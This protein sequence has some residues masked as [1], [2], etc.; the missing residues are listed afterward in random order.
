MNRR[1]A[2][3]SQHLFDVGLQ[4]FR[5]LKRRKKRFI[6]IFFRDLQE[7]GDAE[8]G[9]QKQILG[10]RNYSALAFAGFFYFIDDPFRE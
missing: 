2:D 5:I 1:S 10:F 8:A 7:K 9:K 3:D 6:L 4:K